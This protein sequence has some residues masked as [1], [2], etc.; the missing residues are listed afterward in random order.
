MLAVLASSV[1]F[2]RSG[3]CSASDVRP[4]L[5]AARH[6]AD[7]V[8]VGWV[9]VPRNLLE[10]QLDHLDRKL[11]VLPEGRERLSDYKDDAE[12]NCPGSKS[13]VTDEDVKVRVTH[14][15]TYVA[16]CTCGGR[17]MTYPTRTGLRKLSHLEG[18]NHL[19]RKPHRIVQ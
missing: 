14:S 4:D 9:A 5:G 13:L 10:E 7:V 16:C 1:T 3:A 15:A 6:T 2:G 18:Q 11:G 12:E 19:R 8:P 17:I